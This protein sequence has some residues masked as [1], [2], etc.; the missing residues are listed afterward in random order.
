MSDIKEYVLS[1]EITDPDRYAEYLRIVVPRTRVLFDLV[2]KHLV[3][4]LTLSEIVNYLEPFM[5]YH[6]DLTY[7]QYTDMVGFLR[8]RI[9]DH[10]RNY[11]LLKT[12]CDKVRAHNYGVLHLGLSL[13][14]NL[15]VSGKAHDAA[16]EG[17]NG[18]S[19][20]ETYGF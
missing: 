11:A 12:Q 20:F 14:H 9:R 18:S 13:L 10:K 17:V 4:S 19:V 7:R 2:K 5:V 6:R 16:D 15:L 1:G 8:E 3:G